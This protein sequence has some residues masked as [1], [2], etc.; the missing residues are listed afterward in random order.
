MGWWLFVLLKPLLLLLFAGLYWVAIVLPV[1]ALQRRHP[2]HW[3]L[4][5]RGDGGGA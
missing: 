2:G 1:R 5:E 3:L 4:R